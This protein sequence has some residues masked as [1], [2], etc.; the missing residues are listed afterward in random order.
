VVA[1]S[2]VSLVLGVSSAALAYFAA[3]GS[4]TGTASGASLVAPTS[5]TATP[6][7]G[8]VVTLAWAAPAWGPPPT[9][10]TLVQPAGT[11][12]SGGP[13]SFTRAAAT[14][15]CTVTGLSGSTS[16]AVN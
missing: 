11:A 1:P 2:A 9:G 7:A 10:Y 4:G 13:C 8:G 5:F 15:N 3:T 14:S 16:W 6:G 12:G